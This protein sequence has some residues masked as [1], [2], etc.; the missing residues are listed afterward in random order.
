MHISVCSYWDEKTYFG[1][2]TNK[3]QMEANKS[4]LQTFG[5]HVTL[6]PRNNRKIEI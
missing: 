5:C 1:I 2:F 6:R 4:H 3:Q